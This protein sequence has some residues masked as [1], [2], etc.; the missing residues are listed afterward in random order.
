MKSDVIHLDPPLELMPGALYRLGARVPTSGALS[1]APADVTELMPL[2]VYVLLSNER[3]IVVDTGPRI[4]YPAL[5]EQIRALQG[6]RELAV[7]V[8]R[9]DPEAM[10]GVGSLLS[11]LAP[12]AFYYYG[13]GSILEWVWDDREDLGASGDLFD[14]VPVESPSEIPVAGDRSLLVLRPPL[15]VLNTVWAY[16]PASRT[17]FTSDGLGYLPAGGGPGPDASLPDESL[18]DDRGDVDAVRARAFVNARFD[19]IERINST[20]LADELRELVGPLNIENLAPSHGVIVRGAP[21]V[22]RYLQT[23]LGELARVQSTAQL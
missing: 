4:L 3:A 5:L 21:A 2:N 19:W 18:T 13:G 16:D 15:A 20:R 17:L 9:N 8:T 10:G 1:W 11:E 14:R 23:V 22:N 6:D 7:M 12:V